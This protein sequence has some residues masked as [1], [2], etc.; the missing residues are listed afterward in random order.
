MAHSPV[1]STPHG[2][3]CLPTGADT[4]GPSWMET[5]ISGSPFPSLDIVP[6][7][8]DRVNHGSPVPGFDRERGSG[9][10]KSNRFLNLFP[11]K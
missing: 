8:P 3:D 7:P 11:E 5:L 2:V 9:T 4:Y 1:N 6:C 10:V